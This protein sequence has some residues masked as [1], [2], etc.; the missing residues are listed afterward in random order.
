MEIIDSSLGENRRKIEW[1][2]S[3]EFDRTESW[4]PGSLFKLYDIPL[5][6]QI[7]V[8]F[9]TAPDSPRSYNRENQEYNENR[10]QK[11]FRPE[12]GT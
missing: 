6:T 9:G 8:H 1:K 11:D 7:R 3:Q 2:I 12:L 10:S 5:K 4:I